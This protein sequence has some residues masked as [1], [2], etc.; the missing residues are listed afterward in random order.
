MKD[1]LTCI[2]FTASGAR[3]ECR[4]DILLSSHTF[5]KWC[6]SSANS[7]LGRTLKLVLIKE[8]FV[9]KVSAFQLL[10]IRFELHHVQGYL[11]FF[12]KVVVIWENL[13]L[14]R[15]RPW[16]R[17]LFF[18]IFTGRDQIQLLIYLVQSCGP[19]LRT[20][21]GWFEILDTLGRR[22]RINLHR[23]HILR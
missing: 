11:I 15:H 5:L 8:E 10:L 7:S 2:D 14:G 1:L 3:Q 23:D 20:Y 13:W 9:R 4:C 19:L 22:I 17:K 16:R 6:D 18:L 12:F 21:V